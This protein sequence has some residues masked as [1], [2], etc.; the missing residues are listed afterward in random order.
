MLDAVLAEQNGF[1]AQAV[2]LSEMLGEAR[3]RVSEAEEQLEA[4]SEQVWPTL[5]PGATSW[6]LHGFGYSPEARQVLKRW[7][8]CP[9]GLYLFCDI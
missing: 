6:P 1:L 2:H 7:A 8:V 4:A 5:S 9:Q 3:G